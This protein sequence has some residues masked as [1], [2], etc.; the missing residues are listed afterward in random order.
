MI[1]ACQARIISD[2]KLASEPVP[3]TVSMSARV[4]DLVA[5]WRP[6]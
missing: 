2:L 4:A 1:H 6:T 3:D 5:A